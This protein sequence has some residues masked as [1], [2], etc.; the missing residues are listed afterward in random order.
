MAACGYTRA[1]GAFSPL[2]CPHRVASYPRCS[3][4]PFLPIPSRL[5]VC[6]HC[7]SPSPADRSPCLHCG[8]AGPGASEPEFLSWQLPDH[9]AIP[10][11]AIAAIA[12]TSLTVRMRFYYQMYPFSTAIL[13]FT[14]VTFALLIGIYSWLLVKT[15]RAG[16]QDNPLPLWGLLVLLLLIFFLVY[17]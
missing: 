12:M 1:R 5:L 14:A 2:G 3:W 4:L 9:A 10:F 11:A 7:Q 15:Q 17:H 8:Q 13:I 6:P 16:W